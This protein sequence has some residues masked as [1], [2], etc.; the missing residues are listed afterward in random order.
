VRLDEIVGEALCDV[1][2]DDRIVVVVEDP[3]LVDRDLAPRASLLELGHHRLDPHV[4]AHQVRSAPR[5][6]GTSTPSCTG[7]FV[8]DPRHARPRE[9]L[10]GHQMQT[11][12]D[13]AGRDAASINFP[14][15]VCG[16]T[17]TVA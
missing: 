13:V 2:R 11:L 16:S 3:E 14:G 12:V 1:A 5:G 8:D 7:E 6:A 10:R 15:T 9:D 17:S 4:L